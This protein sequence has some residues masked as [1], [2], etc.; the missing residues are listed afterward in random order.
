MEPRIK[1]DETRIRFCKNRAS[2]VKS[3]MLCFTH[4]PKYFFQRVCAALVALALSMQVSLAQD[5]GG[6]TN[7]AL[8]LDGTN[9]YLELPPNIFTNLTEATVEAWV[10]WAEFPA[11]ARV[12]EFGAGYNSVSLFNHA[13]T[14]DLRFNIY[15]RYAKDNT[16]YM[17]TAT[18]K[19][20]L[21]TNEWIHLATVS[22]PGGMKLYANG[23]L[24]AQHTNTTT[25]ADIH[26]SQTNFLGRGLAN[27]PTDKTFHGEIDEVRVWNHQRPVAQ[28][29]EDMFKRLSGQEPGLTHLWNFDDGT[30]NDFGPNGHHGKLRGKARVGR[31]PDLDLIAS[32][33]P[34]L[35]AAAPTNPPAVIPTPTTALAPATPAT[36]VAAM[37][38]IQV[39]VTAPGNSSA[40][41]V[42]SVCAAVSVGALV[43]FMIL[44]M[45]RNNMGLRQ[46]P[47]GTSLQLEENSSVPGSLTDKEMKERALADLTDFAKQSLVQGLYSQ[48]AALLE[49]HQKAQE[50]LVALEAR[51]VALHLPERIAAYEKRIAELEGELATRGDELRELTMATLQVLR[52][53]LEEEKKKQARPNRFN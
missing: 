1:T 27:N 42:A 20:L 11:F 29:R 41:I 16:K 30:A 18:A 53:K 4:A 14:P 39:A 21:R 43:I 33:L 52:E 26:N 8:K 23:R 32:A 31:V 24:V 36:N 22:G 2:V 5:T 49:V 3:F 38:P 6:F 7:R 12:F 51:V 46:L 19:G 47:G 45:R 9:S 17:F 10:R 34:A 35:T 50:E 15:P 28:I 13:T 44:M 40:I 25:F 37:A 48:R